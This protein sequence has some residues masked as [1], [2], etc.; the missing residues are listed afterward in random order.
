[1][2]SASTKRAR[3]RI[4]SKERPPLKELLAIA[5]PNRSPLQRILVRERAE[6]HVIPVGKIDYIESQDDYV[7]VRTGARSFLKDQPLGELE[8]Q[9][10]PAVFVRIHRRYLLN[11]SRLARIETGVIDSRVAV[12]NDGSHLP[13]SRTGYGRLKDLLSEQSAESKERRAKKRAKNGSVSALR[14]WL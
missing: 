13:I 11:V 14:S 3:A 1:M 6:V 4:S 7:S 9:L 5:R 8:M 2:K 12:L 10:D